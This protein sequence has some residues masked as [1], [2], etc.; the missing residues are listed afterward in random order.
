VDPVTWRS[1]RR[2]HRRAPRERHNGVNKLERFNQAMRFAL[3]VLGD[4][5]EVESWRCGCRREHR[6]GTCVHLLYTCD[7]TAC[8]RVSPPEPL[9]LPGE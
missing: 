6:L 5:V 1:H 3:G 4:E 7:G 2:A 8:Q 9:I